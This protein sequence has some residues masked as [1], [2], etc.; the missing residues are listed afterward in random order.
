M[1]AAPGFDPSNNQNGSPPPPRGMLLGS[2]P[3]AI[4]T[5]RT[6]SRTSKVAVTV[7]CFRV[8]LPWEQ[9]CKRGRVPA[10][11]SAGSQGA[12]SGGSVAPGNSTEER[13]FVVRASNDRSN[14]VAITVRIMLRPGSRRAW[15]GAGRRS[16]F[17]KPPTVL[18]YGRNG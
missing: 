16:N 14:T 7:I 4:L 9:Q 3:M 17:T 1:Y 8:A 2:L 12:A 18:G 5:E 15:Q 13:D 11:M 6:I 10:Q